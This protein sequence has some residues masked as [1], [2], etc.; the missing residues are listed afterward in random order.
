MSW[1][2][3]CVC[4]LLDR[5]GGVGMVW[6][7][8]SGGDELKRMPYGVLVRSMALASFARSVVCLRRGFIL[9]VV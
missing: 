5:F 3:T 2:G 8:R 6:E 4:S 7:R 9:A 1:C